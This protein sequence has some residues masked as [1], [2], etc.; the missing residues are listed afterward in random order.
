MKFYSLFLFGTVAIL[1]LFV[2]EK[3]IIVENKSSFEI[4]NCTDSENGSN[5]SQIK[6]ITIKSVIKS[7]PIY[8]K[9]IY[10]R[11]F[12]T[13]ILMT[14]SFESLINEPTKLKMIEYGVE[15]TTIVNITAIVIPLEIIMSFVSKKFLKKG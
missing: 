11:T 14:R 12:L 8:L 2:S 1:G 9:N 13:Y 5:S 10:V 15:K 7:I 6:K 3:K 4:E